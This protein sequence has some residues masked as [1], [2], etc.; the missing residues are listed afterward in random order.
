MY[1]TECLNP[2]MTFSLIICKTVNAVDDIESKTSADMAD[3]KRQ[4]QAW[5]EIKERSHP[6]SSEI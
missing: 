4:G 1:L 3:E 6:N 2:S 5:D